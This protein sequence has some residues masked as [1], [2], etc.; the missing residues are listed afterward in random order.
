[1]TGQL[2]RFLVVGASNTAITLAVYAALVRAGVSPVTAS[3]AAFGAGAANGFRLNRA[4]TF[5]GARRGAGAG[6]GA[7]YLAVAALG[8]ALNAAGVALAVHVAELPKI[9]G[10]LAALPA[11]TA[12][13]FALSRGWVFGAGGGTRTRRPAVPR[14]R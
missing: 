7:R 5:R 6:A 1:L 8:A 10:E 12:V 3:V 9:A 13:T 4:W 2:A 14:P 11:V